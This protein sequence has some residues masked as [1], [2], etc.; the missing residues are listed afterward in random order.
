M[1][2]ITPAQLRD[3]REGLVFTQGM[4][5]DLLGVGREALAQWESG[6]ASIHPI[7]QLRL[8]ELLRLAEDEGYEQA[9][10]SLSV[11]RKVRQAPYPLRPLQEVMAALDAACE[12]LTALQGNRSAIR[13]QL[14]LQRARHVLAALLR[15]EG[16]EEAAGVRDPSRWA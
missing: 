5:A 4:L 12:S 15:G 3:L 9:R 10:A 6:Q 8:A 13:A 7:W 1:Q 14:E 2:R 11:Q 16:V